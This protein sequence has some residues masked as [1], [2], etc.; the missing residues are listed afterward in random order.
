M[1]EADR[2]KYLFVGVGGCGI[3]LV[4]S[5]LNFRK[6][7]NDN[8]VFINT[9]KKEFYNISSLPKGKKEKVRGFLVGDGSGAGRNPDVG[10]QLI[11]GLK[12][13]MHDAFENYFHSL[14]YGVEDS[15]VVVILHSLSGGSGGGMAPTI[16]ELFYD[17][18]KTNKDSFKIFSMLNVAVFPFRSEVSP[19]MQNAL[20]SFYNLYDTVIA[21]KK[22]SVLLVENDYM[23]NEVL[24]F[25][26][27]ANYANIN[28]EIV[29]R[30]DF[31]F[32]FRQI[33]HDPVVNGLGVFDVSEYMRI[34]S[35]SRISD[36]GMF[37]AYSYDSKTHKMWSWF[38]SYD[39]GEVKR[40]STMNVL[41]FR[42]DNPVNIN[43]INSTIAD[44]GNKFN[45]IKQSV[46]LS[47][48]FDVTVLSNNLS[49][50]SV[51]FNNLTKKAQKDMAAISKKDVKSKNGIK[52]M[53]KSKSKFKF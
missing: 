28:N 7:T 17:I 10:S 48:K 45:I 1:K 53:K 12:G 46:K 36:A 4:S 29:N 11:G 23:A 40:S 19:A 24:K 22:S 38:N 41:I 21:T 49:F 15:I 34:F 8:F 43:V 18:F 14:N 42:N 47:D 52:K 13:E 16:T 33:S 6:N 35:V 50:P 3:N 25:E 27:Q 31:L 20:Y 30:L 26:K 5:L 39:Y 2:V 44:M 51:I 37:N 9:S 32:D